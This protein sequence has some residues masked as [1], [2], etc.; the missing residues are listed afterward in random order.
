MLARGR[1]DTH[2]FDGHRVLAA[3]PDSGLTYTNDAL[4]EESAKKKGLSPSPVTGKADVLVVPY[5]SAGNFLYK[6][7]AMT[8]DAEVANVVI[9]AQAPVILTSRSDSHM[10]KFLTICASA[11]YSQYLQKETSQ[12]S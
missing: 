4:Y 7:W 5:I 10:V 11:V 6:A 9:G 12:S 2:R 8:M 1:P 3:Q